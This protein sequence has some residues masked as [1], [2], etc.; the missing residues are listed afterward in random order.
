MKAVSKCAIAV[1]LAA[2]AALAQNVSSSVR[3]IIVDPSGAAATGAECVLTNQATG[4][5]ANAKADDQG[6]CTFNVVQAGTY[7]FS[8]AAKGFKT[9]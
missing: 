6:A 5:V 9:L 4:A 7:S 1:L 2:V 8:A 3:A